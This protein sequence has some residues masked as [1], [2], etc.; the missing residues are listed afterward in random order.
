MEFPLCKPLMKLFFF[1]T[2]GLT[3]EVV[4]NL[5]P[6]EDQV[7]PA[8]Q[9]AHVDCSEMTEI[10]LYVLNQNRPRHFAPEKLEVK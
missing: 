9:V 5:A 1:Q 10:N 7:A 8:L 2:L 4:L 6:E 3:V